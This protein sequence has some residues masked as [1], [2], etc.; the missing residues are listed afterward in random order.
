MDHHPQTTL[1]ARRDV[2]GVVSVVTYDD[3]PRLYGDGGESFS[4][5]ERQRETSV[6]PIGKRVLCIS[7]RNS[8]LY[9]LASTFAASIIIRE[10]KWKKVRESRRGGH[11]PC[12]SP[13]LLETVRRLS[14]LHTDGGIINGGSSLPRPPWTH[15]QYS[16]TTFLTCTGWATPPRKP[17]LNT[18]HSKLTLSRDVNHIL[19]MRSGPANGVGWG[20]SGEE[21]GSWDTA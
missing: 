11:R 9:S 10:G 14:S 16:S 6:L 15:P 1:P 2:A 19:A 12:N 4:W 8:M 20:W 5:R 3:F 7:N 18:S 21:G 17:C 13:V